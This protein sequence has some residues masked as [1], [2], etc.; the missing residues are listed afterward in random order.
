[1]YFAEGAFDEGFAWVELPFGE[2]P[3]V[4]ARAVHK[5]DFDG[6]VGDSPPD[7]S[8]GCLFCGFL[9][10]EAERV[11]AVLRVRVCADAG[12]QIDRDEPASEAGPSRDPGADVCGI[13]KAMLSAPAQA[14][15]AN[16][17]GGISRNATESDRMIP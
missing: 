12:P 3:V 16:S 8:A 1:M 4:V 2:G 17:V 13:P 5:E 7:E 6:L 10:H 15:N 11:S 9:G 14:G